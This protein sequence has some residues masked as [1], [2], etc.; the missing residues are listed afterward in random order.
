MRFRFEV[1]FFFSI[2]ENLQPFSLAGLVKIS[3][4]IIQLVE[5]STKSQLEESA[6]DLG[7]KSTIW[8]N[9][10]EITKVI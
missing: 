7:M 3:E 5:N 4:D 8:I 10:G 6:K 1:R 9:L 2:S